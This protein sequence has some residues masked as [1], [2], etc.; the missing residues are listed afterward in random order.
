MKISIWSKKVAKF[1]APKQ[2]DR[3]FF[4]PSKFGYMMENNTHCKLTVG[5]TGR[6]VVI[7]M[8]II[9]LVQIK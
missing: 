5:L 8:K 1:V 3:A 7:V 9:P 6:L 2:Q 4:S